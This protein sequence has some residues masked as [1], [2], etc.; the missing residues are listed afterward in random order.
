MKWIKAL[1]LASDVKPKATD[2]YKVI[3]QIGKGRFGQIML[4]VKI[5]TDLNHPANEYVAIK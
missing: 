3:K 4:G 2:K 5:Q 1:S